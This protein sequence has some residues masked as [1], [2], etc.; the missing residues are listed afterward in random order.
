[1][2]KRRYGQ[3]QT[4]G[5]IRNEEIM[6]THTDGVIVLR[7]H[8]A[9]DD[10]TAVVD[11]YNEKNKKLAKREGSGGVSVYQSGDEPTTA[12]VGTWFQELLILY[13]KVAVAGISINF[14]SS[15]VMQQFAGFFLFLPISIMHIML[16]PYDDRELN[17]LE[18]LALAALVFTQLFG[19]LLNVQDTY[20]QQWASTLRFL[21]LIMNV[22]VMALLV[23]FMFKGAV[24]NAIK[25]MCCKKKQEQAAAA[26]TDMTVT[27]GHPAAHAS[28]LHVPAD[29]VNVYRGLVV[30][31]S[32]IQG[33]LREADSQIATQAMHGEDVSEQHPEPPT[34]I[35]GELANDT[36][37]GPMVLMSAAEIDSW[38]TAMTR[39]KLT[40]TLKTF[41]T[42]SKAQA[43]A[44][45]ARKAQVARARASSLARL[46]DIQPAVAQE[47][48]VPE[49][50]PNR[51]VDNPMHTP[52]PTAAA[53]PEGSTSPNPMRNSPAT[54]GS[55]ASPPTIGAPANAVNNKS[56]INP[57]QLYVP[58]QADRNIP[59]PDRPGGLK[60]ISPLFLIPP[61]SAS[62]D[63]PTSASIE[64]PGTSA[65]RAAGV[66]CNTRV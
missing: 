35:D 62:E 60:I 34:T 20:L 37:T 30:L 48:G 42:F 38:A 6:H 33:A 25:S 13:R 51:T 46:D 54:G 8:T 36:A 52:S 19:L 17:M 26:S 1:M 10:R 45:Q 49:F 41:K 40:F 23:I 31:P 16:S 5:G 59:A 47:S 9:G 39:P 58:R 14:A 27:Q 11:Q 57:V 28:V 18:G 3:Q 24:G 32:E 56:V 22:C 64:L 50:A 66:R 12:V 15:V 44:G 53:T 2:K 65:P 4:F 63:R 21:M 43:L 55:P 29:D 61:G 7:N